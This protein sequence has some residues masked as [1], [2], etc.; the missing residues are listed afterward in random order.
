MR[1]SGSFSVSTSTHA[2]FYPPV[3]LS[4]SRLHPRR[5]RR[6]DPATVLQVSWSPPLSL[7]LE[8][9]PKTCSSCYSSR[10]QILGRLTCTRNP[11]TSRH[12][13]SPL[14]P[15]SISGLLSKIGVVKDPTL[16]LSAQK[17]LTRAR[18]RRAH[19]PVWEGRDD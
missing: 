5:V 4:R 15:R 16:P 17:I 19:P 11:V 8:I 14:S 9:L 6:H 2:W 12:E 10:L 7:A 13:A 18:S 3:C 1:R